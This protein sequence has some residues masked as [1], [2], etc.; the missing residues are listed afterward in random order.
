MFFV[1]RLVQLGLLGFT[2]SSGSCSY[3]A[4][5]SAWPSAA[6]RPGSCWP[7]RPPSRPT[8]RSDRVSPIPGAI[9]LAPHGVTVVGM[10]LAGFFA[11]VAVAMALLD[12]ER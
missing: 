6:R 3:A 2:G 11:L 7:R 12:S 9:D 5:A 8:T 10:A 4:T 1:G